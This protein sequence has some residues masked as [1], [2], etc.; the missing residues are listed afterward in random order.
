[1]RQSWSTISA[2]REVAPE[3]ERAGRA[4]RAGA[5]GSRSA[6]RRRAWCGRPRGSTTASMRAPSRARSTRLQRAVLRALDRGDLERRASRSASEPATRA[7]RAGRSV[8]ASRVLD[9]ALVEPAATWS[10][11]QARQAARRRSARAAR[12]SEWSLSLERLAHG[13]RSGRAHGRSGGGSVKKWSGRPSAR[14]IDLVGGAVP[15]RHLAPRRPRARATFSSSGSPASTACDLLGVVHVVR[16]GVELAAGHEALREQ[17]RRSP[18][19]PAGGGGGASS[20][21]GRGS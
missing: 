8:M 4:E 21:T 5:A 11:R 9:A 2:V 18:A 1:M 17:R 10:A 16:R 14:H 15:P 20:A 13:F 6:S 7:A 12:P 19:G 3:A